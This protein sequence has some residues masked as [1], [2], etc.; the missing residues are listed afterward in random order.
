[1]KF[2]KT[3]VMNIENAIRG[4]RNPLESWNNS[5]SY[6]GYDNYDQNICVIGDNDLR[7]LQKLIIA[8]S[9]HRKFM[10]QIIVSVDIIAPL[11]WFKEFDTYKINTVANSTSTMHKLATTP[12]TINC[13]EMDDFENIEYS[14]SEYDFSTERN[15]IAII[16]ALETLRLK[17]LDTKDKRYWKELIR[18]LPS[19][20]L[21]TRTVTMNYENL[22]N[23]IQSRKN[24]KLTEWSVDFINWAKTLPYSEELLFI[25]GDK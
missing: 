9:D 11:Y 22:L 10:R 6:M 3:N 21:Q 18:Q 17:Y 14:S 4:A 16:N 24:H 7:L 13:F 8:G 25:G 12:I 1:M 15:W 19:S 5:D 23:M 2:E 20:W